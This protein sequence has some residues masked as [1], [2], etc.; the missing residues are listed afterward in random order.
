MD[1]LSNAPDPPPAPACDAVWRLA[2]CL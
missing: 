1:G 2:S